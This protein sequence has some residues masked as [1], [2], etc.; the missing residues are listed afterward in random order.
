[1][2]LF[3]EQSFIFLDSEIKGNYMESTRVTINLPKKFLEAIEFLVMDF[4]EPITIEEYLIDCVRCGL[5]A[6][7]HDVVNYCELMNTE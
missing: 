7:V 1:M 4:P 2:L 3:V 6:D 5:E